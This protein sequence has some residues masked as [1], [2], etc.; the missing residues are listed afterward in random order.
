MAFKRALWHSGLTYQQTCR[1]CRTTISYTD[2]SL[3]FR[4]WFA[5]GFVYCP[6]CRTP[7]RHHEQYAIDTPTD[8]VHV[9]VTP[10][11]APSAPVE[12]APAA[13]DT[14]ILFC[15]KCGKQFHD[16]DRFCSGCGSPRA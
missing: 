12:S 11:P 13:V 1:Q 14:A 3:D 8:P 10:P 2:H 4:P 9:A 6:T 15:T 16:E 5:D 7:L